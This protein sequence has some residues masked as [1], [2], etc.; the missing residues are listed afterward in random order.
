[1]I[2]KISNQ[3]SVLSL[4]ANNSCTYQKLVERKMADPHFASKIQHVHSNHLADPLNMM[5]CNSLRKYVPREVEFVIT[6]S[7]IDFTKRNEYLSRNERKR[8][9]KK[10]K[11]IVIIMYY[12]LHSIRVRRVLTV[13]QSCPFAKARSQ[14]YI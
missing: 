4:H 14:K 2:K 9:R 11:K 6:V 1:M 7:P 12:T 3:P 8:K 10:K 13:E 5:G